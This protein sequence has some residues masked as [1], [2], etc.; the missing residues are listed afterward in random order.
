MRGGKHRVDSLRECWI[1]FAKDTR[2]R[3]CGCFFTTHPR[4]E[5]KRNPLFSSLLLIARP[6]QGILRSKMSD[7]VS[8]SRASSLAEG[9]ESTAPAWLAQAKPCSFCP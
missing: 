7:G 5:I 1:C 4:L 8:K 6:K 9:F 2:K 3:A